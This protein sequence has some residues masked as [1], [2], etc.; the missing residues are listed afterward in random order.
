MLEAYRKLYEQCADAIPDWK[1]INK[2]DLANKYLKFK[3]DPHFAN[4]Y[5][6]ALILKY[7]G[8]LNKY[9]LRSFRSA[10]DETFLE[11][12]VGAILRA[13]RDHKWTDPSNKLYGD[14]NGPDKVINRCIISERLIWYQS[15]NTD[16]RRL[17]FQA[18]SIENLND[19]LGESSPLPVYEEDGCDASTLDIKYLVR[20][21]FNQREYATA[22]AIDGIINYDTFERT[23]D[24][25]GKYLIQFN[26][27]KLMRHLGKLGEPFCKAF[28]SQFNI[29]I[30]QVR[31]AAEE[32]QHLSRNR[33]QRQV[34]R[35]LAA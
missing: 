27:K 5:L 29:P 2:N 6:S 19:L 20:K 9:K 13:L 25:E 4:A 33:R 8:A 1:K 7:W 12:L 23:K 11:W 21:F 17:N 15:A 10:E 18:T 31:C 35:G 30:T 34:D 14:P 16:K 24:E 28:A 26:K 3:D 32:F 22:F